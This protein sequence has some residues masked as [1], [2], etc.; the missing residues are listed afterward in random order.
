MVVLSKVNRLLEF[1]LCTG[2]PRGVSEPQNHQNF[3]DFWLKIAIF[4]KI[5]LMPCFYDH[6]E[7]HPFRDFSSR[8]G[9]RK[10]PV[11]PLI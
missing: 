7:N 1:Q 8:P 4:L 9:V 3:D 2:N 6:D 5:A 11:V 10:P